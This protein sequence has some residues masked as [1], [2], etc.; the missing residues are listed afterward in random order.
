[1]LAL[2]FGTALDGNAQQSK[3]FKLKKKPESRRIKSSGSSVLL[4]GDVL[5]GGHYVFS[6]IGFGALGDVSY[7]LKS[8]IYLEAGGGYFSESRNG[9]DISR[10]SLHAGGKYRAFDLKTI[11]GFAG[12]V[13]NVYIRNFQNLTTSTR[14]SPTIWGPAFFA[15]L[16]IG[17]LP[18]LSLAARAEQ[19]FA[20]SEQV[21]T[22]EGA[23]EFYTLANLSIGLRKTL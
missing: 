10:I 7:V 9:I 11:T 22:S 16:S 17:I 2:L 15:E 14:P 20:F 19:V 23:K 13:I 18:K 6:P 12:A 4:A 5:I 21:Q 8:N 3:R 1:M